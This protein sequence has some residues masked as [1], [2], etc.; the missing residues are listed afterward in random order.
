[1]NDLR[2][3]L[4]LMGFACLTSCT[5]DIVIDVQKGEPMIGVEASFTDELKRH[6]AILSYSADFYNEDDI[7]MVSG[8]T[9][10]VTDGTDTVYYYEDAECKGHYFSDLVAG[11]KNTL[12]RFCADVPSEDG[13]VVHVFAESLMPNNVECIDSIVIKPYNGVN[14]TMP[15]VIFN[16]TIEWIY[17]YF[18]S[19]PDPTIVFMPLVAKNDTIVNDTLMQQLIVPVG[20]YAGYYIN[21]PEMQLANKEI[22]VYMF[23]KSKL[24]RGDRIRVDFHSIPPDYLTFFYSI[25]MSSGS[26]PLLGAPANVGTNIQP[27]GSGVGWF[28]TASV[29]SAETVFE[30]KY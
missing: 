1:M 29:V 4:V 28:L 26:N 14:D 19:L 25:A 11:R 21:G 6:E 30:D 8:A 27:S 16:D 12:Y 20:G 10:Y 9:V 2:K 13:E 24:K 17:P 22:P 5:E 15:S 7:R 23:L 18:M 3:L